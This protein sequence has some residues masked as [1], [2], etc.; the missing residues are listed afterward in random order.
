MLHSWLLALSVNGGTCFIKIR[1]LPSRPIIDVYSWITGSIL[2]AANDTNYRSSKSHRQTWLIRLIN[3]RQMFHL[4]NRGIISFN[5]T[6]ATLANTWTKWC[7]KLLLFRIIFTLE[8]DEKLLPELE[9]LRE[10]TW[11]HNE[12]CSISKRS[13]LATPPYNELE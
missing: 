11:H 7:S 8:V 6:W 3:Y 1:A 5:S 2:L 12:T 13:C 4:D 10:F 9:K